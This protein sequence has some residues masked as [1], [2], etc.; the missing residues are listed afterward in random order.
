MQL[1]SSSL[2]QW[3]VA[4]R[5]RGISCTENLG[6]YGGSFPPMG[7]ARRLIMRVTSPRGG[8]GP[9]AEAPPQQVMDKQALD[10]PSGTRLS[11][12]V[13]TDPADIKGS[14]P[15]HIWPTSG[16]NNICMLTTGPKLARQ[17]PSADQGAPRA[18]GEACNDLI[19]D[20]GALA[21]SRNVRP[22]RLSFIFKIRL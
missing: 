20:S 22:L 3:L 15:V 12:A 16:A 4:S 5:A 2:P 14:T 19:L 18:R 13:K 9:G 21:L 1:F 8:Q 7:K 10:W 11:A 17:A 6:T